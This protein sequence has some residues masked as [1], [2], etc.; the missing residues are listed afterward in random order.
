LKYKYKIPGQLRLPLPLDT[1]SGNRGAACPKCS[2]PM[3]LRSHPPGWQPRPGQPYFFSSWDWCW[4][5]SHLQHYN[6]RKIYIHQAVPEPPDIG[7]FDC[8]IPAADEV[9]CL[10][11]IGVLAGVP[12]YGWALMYPRHLTRDTRV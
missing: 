10:V 2:R 7:L 1:L 3:E 6:D 8:C 5:C 12:E 4:R 11:A 9:V